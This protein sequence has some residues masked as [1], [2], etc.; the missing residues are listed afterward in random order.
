MKVVVFIHLV[1]DAHIGKGASALADSFLSLLWISSVPAEVRILKKNLGYLKT[2]LL[3][4]K[5]SS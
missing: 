3:W 2:L 4:A 1:P 5:L